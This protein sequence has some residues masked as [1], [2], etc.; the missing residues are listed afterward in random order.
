VGTISTTSGSG[1]R[2]RIK[3][4]MDRAS[5]REVPLAIMTIIES[6]EASRIS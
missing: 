4:P 1:S 2:R 6:N 3:D 5:K